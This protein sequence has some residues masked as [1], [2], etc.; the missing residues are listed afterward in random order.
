MTDEDTLMRYVRSRKIYC[1]ICG[2]P[3]SDHALW[4][5]GNCEHRKQIKKIFKDANGREKEGV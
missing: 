2:D 3:I 1:P 4:E 5:L